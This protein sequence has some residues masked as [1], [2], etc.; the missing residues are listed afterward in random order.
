M[1]ISVAAFSSQLQCELSVIA[2]FQCIYIDS[3]L[4]IRSR[5]FVQAVSLYALSIFIKLIEPKLFYFLPKCLLA[6]LWK[7]QLATDRYN[8]PF[9]FPVKK[10]KIKN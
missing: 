10:E 4:R 1:I 9:P 5:L 2:Q 6:F 7:H 3:I 8:N